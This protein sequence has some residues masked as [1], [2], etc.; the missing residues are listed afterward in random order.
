MVMSSQIIVIAI[1]NCKRA[2]LL[3]DLGGTGVSK[4]RSG[5]M[6]QV[7]GLPPLPLNDFFVNVIE[8]LG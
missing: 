4:G 7:R 8:P 3:E 1:C 2:V 6:P 5:G